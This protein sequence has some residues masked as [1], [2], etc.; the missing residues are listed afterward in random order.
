M[1]GS[2]LLRPATYTSHHHVVADLVADPLVRRPV[3]TLTAGA[4]RAA[5]VRWQVRV[6]GGHGVGPLAG[7]ALGDLV[8]AH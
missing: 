7:A 8:G 5:I 1:A 2:H 6:V 4:V 3:L